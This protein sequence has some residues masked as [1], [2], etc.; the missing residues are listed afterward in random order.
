MRYLLFFLPLLFFS[1]YSSGQDQGRKFAIRGKILDDNGTA[2]PFA[3]VALYDLTST[4]ITGAV[5][6]DQ[7]QFSIQAAPGTY[8]LKITF[9]SYE[10]KT[11]PVVKVVASDVALGS[12]Q[13]KS[14]SQILNEVTIQGEKS[15]MEL[16]LDKRVFQVGKDLSNISSSASDILDNVPSVTVDMEGNVSLRGSQ[17]VRILIDGKPSG[18]TGISTADALRQL[19]GNLIESVEVITNPSSRYDAEGEVGI[20]NIVLKKERQKGING[21]FSLNAGHPDNFGASYSM[22]FRREKMNFFS[23]YGFNYRTNPGKGFSYQRIEEDDSVFVYDERR[24]RTRSDNGHNLRAGMDYFLN[25]KNT[26]TGS[27]LLRNS[28]GLNT[29]QTV[30]SDYDDDVLLRTVTRNEREKE[31]ELNTETSINYRKDFAQKGRQLTADFKWIENIETE[32]ADFRQTDDS[33]PDSI[34]L[35]RS[36]NTENERNLL[37]QADYVHPFGKSG[38][39]EAGIKSTQRVLDNKFYVQQQNEDGEWVTDSVF[40]NHLIYHENIH[41]LYFMLG[42]E[43]PDGKFAWQTGLRGELTDILA[44]FVNTPEATSKQ[45]YFNIFP[46]A[47]LSY[48]FDT[49]KTL[50]LSYSYRLSRPRFR[51][52]LPFSGYSNNRSLFIGNPNLRPEFTHSI[53]TGYLLNW[54]SGSALSSIYYRYRTGVHERIR[55]TDPD[56]PGTTIMYP[57]NLGKENAYGLEFT[58]SWTPV[59]WIRLNSNANFYRAITE[60]SFEDQYL[61]SDTYTWTTRT[62]SRFTFF[63][64]WDFQAGLNYRGPRQTPQGSQRAQYAI[65]LGLSRDLFKD[66]GTLTFS[67]RDLLNSRKWRWTT[68]T[69]N[70]YSTGEFQWRSRQM[71]LTFTYRLNRKKERGGREEGDRNGDFD[72]GADF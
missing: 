70:I 16:H 72:G 24:K 26:L 52:L 54:K 51:E 50:Q 19:Q 21:S 38:K 9:L 62:T 15:Q 31:P 27:F 11:I 13:L 64:K 58:L 37:L 60:G 42:N 69:D 71:T 61:F 55:L 68:D 32:E 3:N 43:F 5:S 30:F 36:Y 39:W 44:E 59:H 7:G 28:N 1:L 48:K 57:I 66:N 41:A 45:N 14:S 47:H 20:I 23:S 18:L 65:D 34:V 4:L 40:D 63:K 8:S 17:N 49:E 67:V 22:N 12:I 6:D 35:Q 29:S 25:E 10:E 33:A 46:S 2:V 56:N 53:E